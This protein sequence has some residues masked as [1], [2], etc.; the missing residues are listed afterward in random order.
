MGDP[1]KAGN[2]EPINSSESSLP[3]EAAFPTFSEELNPIL[4]EELV[5]V[6]LILL[7]TADSLHDPLSSSFFASR[8]LYKLKY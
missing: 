7:E 3:L 6:S 5:M 8:S 4:S 1:N 2:I